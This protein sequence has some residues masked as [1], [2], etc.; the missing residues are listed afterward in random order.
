MNNELRVGDRVPT[1]NSGFGVVVEIDF[2]TIAPDKLVKI[3][4]SE[5]VYVWVKMSEFNT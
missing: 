4:I 3:R 1:D 5:N 2:C